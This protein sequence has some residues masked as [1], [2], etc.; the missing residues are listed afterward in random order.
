MLLLSP[1]LSPQVLRSVLRQR[2]VSIMRTGSRLKASFSF[3]L[4]LFTLL[5]ACLMAVPQQQGNLPPE[6]NEKVGVDAQ[7]RQLNGRLVQLTKISE[8]MS[9]SRPETLAL[10]KSQQDELCSQLNSLTNISNKLQA[11]LEISDLLPQFSGNTALAAN[12]KLVDLRFQLSQARAGQVPVPALACTPA[13]V[14]APVAGA[15]ASP[16]PPAPA[17]AAPG[18]AVAPAPAPQNAAQDSNPVPVKNGALWGR[19][20]DDASGSPVPNATILARCGDNGDAEYTTRTDSNGI[21]QFTQI[22]ATPC[23]IRATK[24]LNRPEEELL[25]G[26]DRPDKQKLKVDSGAGNAEVAAKVDQ[27]AF[28]NSPPISLRSYQTRTIKNVVPD[29]TGDFSSLVQDIR[30]SERR[31][32]IG[33]FART[34]VGFEQSG[35]SSAPS[36]QT[37]FTDFWVSVPFALP[38][39]MNRKP[40]K[41]AD[42]L[43]D[44]NFGNRFRLWG[45][46]RITSAPQQISSSVGDFAIGFADQ[47]SAVKVNQVAQATEF[48][49][50]GEYRL[51]HWGLTSH[52]FLSFDQT[53]RERFA[54]YFT[55]GYGTV[56]PLNPKDSVQ[57]FN[58]P[59]PGSEPAFDD[60]MK[61]LGLTDQ[62]Q[63]KS[64]VAFVPDDRYRFYK[65]YYGGI[66]V[67]TFYYDRDTDEPLG[68][69]PA[70][71]EAVLGQN[72]TITG[73]RLHGAVLRLEGFYPLPYDAVHFVYLFG[74]ADLL[75]SGQRGGNAIILQEATNPP[76]IPDPSVFLIRTP[77]L[78]RDHYRLGVGIDF[79]QVVNAIKNRG[80]NNPVVSNLAPATTQAPAPAPAPAAGAPTVP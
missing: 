15:P 50:G 18:P 27:I 36:V 77:Q 1:D 53:N 41:Y 37:F 58:N 9:R 44:F 57:V 21:Y 26:M 22:T 43:K 79:L 72:E 60:Q 16:P 54:A 3:S 70:S 75:M 46:F 74:T 33:E 11:I 17:V 40:P 4:L 76:A 52:R 66:R 56:T 71:F 34:I 29:T 20:L 80:K 28:K 35:A 67:K 49:V 63:G 59:P 30:L 12:R 23:L 10:I 14:A 6:A 8:D 5:P 48:M 64:F 62:I 69:F 38:R 51:Y 25:D 39:F 13:A 2:L 42:A 19:I 47:I 7:I 32:S 24:F 68:R 73:G 61:A 55:V 65:Q 31:A 45:D 78:N